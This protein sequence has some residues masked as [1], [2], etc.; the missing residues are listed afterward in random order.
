MAGEDFGDGG[1]LGGGK[2]GEALREPRGE[3]G[4]Q[5]GEELGLGERGRRDGDVISHC[6]P[7]DEHG[8]TRLGED[9]KSRD[10]GEAAAG[11]EGVDF[12]GGFIGAEAGDAG[13]AESEAA[14]VA[15]ARL[16]IVERD[17]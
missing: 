5:S 14:L 10:A 9:A 3:L 8:W 6:L 17:F 15:C 2:V 16:D 11:C 12:G 1:A 7:K 13:E 4:V